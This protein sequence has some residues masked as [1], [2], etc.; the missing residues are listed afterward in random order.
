MLKMKVLIIGVA[1]SI[2]MHVAEQLLAEGRVRVLDRS[3]QQQAFDALNS[4]PA[5]SSTL[6]HIH[7]VG[8]HRPIDMMT[9]IELIE[10]AKK[11]KRSRA[12]CK[13]ATLLRLMQT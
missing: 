11:R 4:D 1:G 10:R 9:Y 2:D 13:T 5:S 6:Y 12:H 7:N 8:R 3:F